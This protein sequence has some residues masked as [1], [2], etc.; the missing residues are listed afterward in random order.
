MTVDGNVIENG[1]SETRRSTGMRATLSENAVFT[2]NTLNQVTDGIT[3]SAGS[4]IVK[5]NVLKSFSRGIWVTGG[6][7]V[8]EGNTLLPNAY[9]GAAES[10]AVS[11][12]NDAGAV[13]KGNLFKNYKNYP[14]FSSTSSGTSVISNRFES[15]PLIVTVYLNSG[16]H[17]VIDNT[18]TI[19]RTAGSP[20]GIY[21]NGASNSLVSGNTINNLSA[22]SA[23]A[24][25]TSSSAS[26]KI[27]GNRIIKGVIVKHPTDTESGNIV[28]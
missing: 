14:V 10:Y 19:N 9:Q 3:M 17:E 23:S 15:S 18:L 11:V 4:I 1:R 25:Q 12:T 20:I 27:I 8:I 5:Q 24:I 21:L 22:A 16:T 7:A 13:I 28:I 6:N 26:T 2:N